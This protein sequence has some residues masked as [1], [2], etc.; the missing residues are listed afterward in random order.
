GNDRFDGDLGKDTLIGGTGNDTYFFTQAG[1]DVNEDQVIE[2]AGGGSDTIA[3]DVDDVDLNA[4]SQVEN[5]TLLGD[6]DIDGTGTDIANRITGNDG[7]NALTGG[8][9]DDTLDGGL[10]GDVLKGGL[11]N[12]TYFVDSL[13]DTVFEAEGEG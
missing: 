5:L 6:E 4:F 12:D 9:G 10:N 1:N 13:T 3:T 11:G 2:V 8:K 7:K